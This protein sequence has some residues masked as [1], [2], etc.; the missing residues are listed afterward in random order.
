LIQFAKAGA[1]P[2]NFDRYMAIMAIQNPNMDQSKQEDIETL[3]SLSQI[4]VANEQMEL[5]LELLKNN[6][7]TFKHIKTTIELMANHGYTYE[8][9]KT[10][11]EFL[12]ENGFTNKL[13]KTTL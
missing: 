7:F 5:A 13:I 10:R 2:Q 12:K 1:I 3:V 9:I 4:G 11:V 6:G 8:Q